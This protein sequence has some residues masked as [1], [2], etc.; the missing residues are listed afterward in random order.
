MKF[1]P[2]LLC[3]IKKQAEKSPASYRI[4]GIAISQRGNILG[5]SFSSFRTEC[6]TPG[7]GTGRHCEAALI[8]RYGRKIATIIIMR[9]GNSG[10]VLRIEPC[11][12]CQKMADK[13]GIK[14]VSV[15]C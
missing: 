15:G 7:K 4:G 8:K 2:S 5:T 3:F 1:N 6:I 9:I 13:L 12:N 14:I 10:N 11:A